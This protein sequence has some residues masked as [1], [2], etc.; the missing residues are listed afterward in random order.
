MMPSAENQTDLATEQAPNQAEIIARIGRRR[1]FSRFS[2]QSKLIVMLVLCAIV[3]AAV[4]VTNP[5]A[6]LCGQRC[7]RG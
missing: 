1:L 5:V 3:S 4:S 7:S 6:A 2:I